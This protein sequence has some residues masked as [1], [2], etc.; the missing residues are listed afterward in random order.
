M[1]PHDHSSGDNV[2]GKVTSLNRK[3]V[4]RVD[5]GGKRSLSPPDKRRL[6]EACLWPDASLSGLALKEALLP[7]SCMHGFRR[8]NAP[9]P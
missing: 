7:T 8:V 9:G 4:T 5:V 3:R 2:I 6:V 1:L